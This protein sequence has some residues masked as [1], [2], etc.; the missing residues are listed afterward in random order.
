MN[1]YYR[2]ESRR[3]SWSWQDL[4]SLS[5]MKI[6]KNHFFAMHMKCGINLEKCMIGF[7]VIV[8]YF[9]IHIFINQQT[10]INET[11]PGA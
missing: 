2:L 4:S 6:L 5:E 11:L 10:N 9:D 3:K 1:G 8:I 7:I